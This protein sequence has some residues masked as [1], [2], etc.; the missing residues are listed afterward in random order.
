MEIPASPKHTDKQSNG[1]SIVRS[2]A[3]EP[4]AQSPPAEEGFNIAQILGMLRRK[5]PIVIAV[6]IAASAF[7][8]FQAS[9]KT[10]MF[11][12]SFALLVEP[13]TQR[14][15]LS[16][17]TDGTSETTKELD[18][19][20]QIEVMLSPKTLEPM[21]KE[22]NDRYPD[23]SFGMLSSRL[24]VNRLGETKIIEV[25][26]SG[27]DPA[28]V[29]FI[30]EKLSQGYLKHSLDEQKITLRQGIRFVDEQLPGLKK[31]VNDLQQQIQTL[32]Q[33]YNFVDP[34]AY[35][36]QMT[37]QLGSVAQ[38]RQTIQAEMATLRARYA[39]LQQQI[40]ATAA[41]NNA[42]FYQD[43]LQQFQAL[44]RQIAIESARFGDK[45]PTIRMLQQQQENLAPLLQ[46]EATRALGNQAASLLNEMQVLQMR[47]RTI[48]QAEQQISQQFK[49]TP[50]LSRE[51]SD[52]QRELKSATESL[53]RFTDTRESLEIQA[54]QNEVPWQLITPPT[55]PTS[56]VASNVYK[57]LI[58]GAVM[59][60]TLGA[61]LAF[62]LEK[63]ESAFFTVA[64][65]KRKTKLPI[66]G[67]IPFHADL[68]YAGSEAHIVDLRHLNPEGTRSVYRDTEEIKNRLKL[69]LQAASVQ[70]VVESKA[71]FL[72]KQQIDLEVQAT[73]GF[74]EAFRALYAAIEGLGKEQPIRSIVIS[75]ALPVE[76]RTT[77]AVHLA[78]AAAALGKRVLLVDVHLRGGSVQ[79]H[80]LLNIRRNAGLSQFLREEAPLEQIIQRLDWE[81][82]LFFV[83]AGEVP[84]DPTRLLASKQMKE[85]MHRVHKTFDLVIYDTLPLMG[86]ADVTLIA[87]ETDGVVM[88][89]GFGKWGGGTAFVQTVERLES[90]QIRVLGVVA[91]GVKNYSVDLYAR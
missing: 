77:I 43:F 40:G 34:D 68:E 44:D 83:G 61:A 42:E 86:L 74:L 50:A 32:R 16:Q 2:T 88:V 78:Q 27:T 89:T 37:V 51:F 28:K 38:Q 73:Y 5:A 72:P 4:A 9:R 70:E 64:D 29:K 84:P 26:Y 46:N 80:N 49:R 45:S 55:E 17:L 91:N 53:Q 65:L 90:A 56:Q 87:P 60:F 59:G 47:D 23:V 58:T 7:S 24:G 18:Y 66:L 76:G 75:S 20:T 3:I 6:A 62:L 35:A 52:L 81:A 85:F 22:I 21:I 79:I 15:Q 63:V 82:G 12:S 57:S 1:L 33:Q 48:A 11:Q 31:R 67:V 8:G 25:S 71:P 39:A 13:V 36:Q 14:K 19:S 69:L 54:A 10:P 41:L 30:L